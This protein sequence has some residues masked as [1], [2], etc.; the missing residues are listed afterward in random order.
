MKPKACRFQPNMTIKEAFYKASSCLQGSGQDPHRV[1]EWLLQHV[2]GCDRAA[3]YLNWTQTLSDPHRLE[4]ERLLQR[5]LQ[6]EPIQYIIGYQ[7]FMGL[8][9][10]VDTRVL[11]PRPETELLVEEVIRRTRQLFPHQTPV[12]ADICTGSGAIAVAAAVQCPGWSLLATDISEDALE[13]AKINAKRH[14]VAERI[15]FLQGHLLEPLPQGQVDVVVSNPPYIASGELIGLQKEVGDF[16]PKLALDG[17]EDG[18][19][20]YREMANVLACWETPPAL[21]AFEV[22]QGQA[23]TLVDILRTTHI[24]PELDVIEDLAGIKRHVIAAR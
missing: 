10:K 14:H 1:S 12:V 11:I 18:Y 24:W 6:G 5:K 4:L 23:E 13:V 22:G 19:R 16:E 3:L 7:E 20:F 21:A 15:T 8:P 9:F 2:L 17:G